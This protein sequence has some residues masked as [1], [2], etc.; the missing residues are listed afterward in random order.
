MELRPVALIPSEI[1]SLIARVQ[2]SHPEEAD[3]ALE[4]LADKLRAIEAGEET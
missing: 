3:K 4:E 2:R 1:L